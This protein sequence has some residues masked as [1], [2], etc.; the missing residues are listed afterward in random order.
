M[1][2]QVSKS[3]ENIHCTVFNFI[4]S[5]NQ[6][7]IKGRKGLLADRENSRLKEKHTYLQCQQQPRDLWQVIKTRLG[8][9]CN[10]CWHL[11]KR[12]RS[13]KICLSA[14][15]Q[16]HP[17]L[18]QHIQAS[19]HGTVSLAHV[20]SISTQKNQLWTT[21]QR[22]GKMKH[23]NAEQI[24]F[25]LFVFTFNSFKTKTGKMSYCMSPKIMS[26]FSKPT[27]FV[28][29]RALATKILCTSFGSLVKP[30]SETEVW[31]PNHL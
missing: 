3:N 24:L 29:A 4:L 12:K 10:Y 30:M 25:A 23:E 7:G 18:L 9:I 1:T 2:E 17:T 5:S 22:A 20:P 21:K 14:N 26:Q 31:V 27:A 6:W 19:M 28:L 16:L 8:T 15:L 13:R 11:Q